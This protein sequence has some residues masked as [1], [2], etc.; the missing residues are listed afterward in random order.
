MLG[1]LALTLAA[2]SIA[3][4]V[5]EAF[6]GSPPKLRPR[7]FARNRPDLGAAGGTELLALD[8]ARTRRDCV[9]DADAAVADFQRR[10]SRPVAFAEV[11]AVVPLL[12]FLFGDLLVKRLDALLAEEA[13]DAQA[14][15][16]LGAARA[17]STDRLRSAQ[18]RARPL[19]LGVARAR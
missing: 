13:D 7:A 10:G 14:L 3:G 17:G 18:R 12:A 9:A 8:R 16:G 2:G 5:I 19:L 1:A 15:S 6:D 11:E 4:T